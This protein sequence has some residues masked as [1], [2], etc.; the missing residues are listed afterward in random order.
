MNRSKIIMIANYVCCLW[1]KTNLIVIEFQNA[2]NK[3][4]LKS[5]LESRPWHI[6]PIRIEMSY[7]PPVNTI[8]IQLRSIL[9]YFHFGSSAPITEYVLG[10]AGQIISDRVPLPVF[11]LA[12]IYICR[13]L[14]NILCNNNNLPSHPSSPE[15]NNLHLL[16]L[17]SI[18]LLLLLYAYV[19]LS[20]TTSRTCNPSLVNT[21]P[22]RSNK[23]NSCHYSSPTN[24]RTAA[25]QTLFLY[26]IQK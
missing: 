21:P 20:N 16:P 12:M 11:S 7:P 18:T 19:T 2:S 17:L 4:W 1:L 3:N 13:F 10:S 25:H 9:F 22:H 14:Q 24:S 23:L 15:H 5:I 6:F 26:W 8:S